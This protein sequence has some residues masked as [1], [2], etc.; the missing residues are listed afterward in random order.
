MNADIVILCGGVGSRLTPLISDRPKPMADINGK[1]FL[2]LV[3]NYYRSFGAWRFILCTGHMSDFIENYYKANTQDVE[4]VLSKE[5]TPLGTAGGVKNAAKMIK[6]EPF[7]VINGD[8][9]CKVDVSDFYAFHRRMSPSVSMAV[10]EVKDAHSYGSVIIDTS[11]RITGFMEKSEVSEKAYI[12]AGIYL[13]NNT[14]V[15]NLI[16]SETKYSLEYDFFPKIAGSG[17]F[18]G[19]ITNAP[20]FDI[21]TP[22]RYERALRELKEIHL[23]MTQL[24]IKKF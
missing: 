10:T 13:F 2:D 11:Q 23:Q 12:N 8:S 3:I 9:F 4:I 1:P 15:L 19:Y 20:L 5:N 14:D 18:Y 24:R 6:S 16:P 22:E 7:F 21:G 17:A